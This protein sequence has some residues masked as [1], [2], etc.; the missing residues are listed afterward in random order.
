MS[1]VGHCFLSGR[2]QESGWG[3]NCQPGSWEEEAEGL[4]G[5]KKPVAMRTVLWFSLWVDV[6]REEGKTAEEKA[7][8]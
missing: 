8:R 7:P 6:C 5:E 3:S 2:S 1:L 4:D